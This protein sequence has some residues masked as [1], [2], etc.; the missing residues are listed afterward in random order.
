[1]K[2]AVRAP[3]WIGDAVLSLPALASL[4]ANDPR[5]EVWVI[6]HDWVK[7]L[8]AT[9]TP[10]AGVIAL[11]SDRSLRGLR[12]SARMLR[13]EKFDA[14]LLLTGSF[15]SALLFSM[16]RIPERWGYRGDGRGWLLTRGVTVAEDAPVVHQAEYY[17]RL[18]RGLGLKTVTPSVSL[19]LTPAEKMAGRT[20]LDSLGVKTKQPVIVLNPGAAYGPAKRWPAGNFAALATLLQSRYR[21]QVVIVGSSGEA[22]LAA[23]VA[24][25]MRRKP[26]VL[27]GQTTLRQLLGVLSRSQLFITNDS[28]PM[29]MANAL[30]VPVI[31][32][33]GPTDPTVTGPCQPPSLVIWKGAPCWPCYY[34]KCPFGHECL[35]SITPEEVLEAAACYL[36]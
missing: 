25:A 11:G 23:A 21:A 7:D 24:S 10:A 9:G 2:I 15:G 20:I 29:H 33:F 28:G 31:G 35:T 22:D 8:F 4:K 13:E 16:A 26:L 17:L 5:S 34:R 1:M 18:V 12:A 32:L 6:A 14:G 27:S 19:S 36:R 3:N 30:A